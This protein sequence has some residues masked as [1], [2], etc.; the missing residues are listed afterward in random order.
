MDDRAGTRALVID[1]VELAGR[2]GRAVRLCDGRVVA[3]GDRHQLRGDRHDVVIDGRGGALLRGLHDHHLHLWS[4][5]A[6]LASVRCGPPEVADVH[7]MAEALRTV[8]ARHPPGEWLRGIGYHESVAGEL[9]RTVLDGMVADRPVRIQHRSG[10]LWVLNTQ[11]TLRCGLPPDSDGRLVR[12]DHEFRDRWS[13]PGTPPDLAAVGHLLAAA[14][15]TG[16]TDATATNGRK[17]LA[18]LDTAS[19]AGDIQ[20]RILVLGGPDMPW[21]GPGP[22]RAPGPDLSD[23]VTVG[24]LKIVLDEHDLP[25]LDGCEGLSTAIVDAHRIGRRVAV[26][27]VTEAALILTLSA[28]DTAG[29][30]AGDRIEHASLVPAEVLPWMARLGLTVVTQPNFVAERGDRYREDLPPGSLPKLYR[31]ATL[32]QAGVRLAAGTDAPF[33]DP[34]PWRAMRAA[35]DRR[36]AAGRVLGPEDRL[37][38]E[39]ALAL[40]LGPPARPG[41][42]PAAIEVGGRADLCLLRVPWAAARRELAR[43]LVAATVCGGR[44]V[45]LADPAVSRLN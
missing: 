16:V 6:S 7:G 14:G 19:A 21:P 37:D 5:A 4:L 32:L 28:F 39:Q 11:A 26:H 45:H 13:E 17:E 31:A 1:D 40:F 41:G 3:V 22:F 42:P 33:G 24:G 15:I 29:A 18:A 36:T 2:P 10:I 20:Q 34:D 35:V 38:P 25:G 23:R 12:L 30:I 8:A 27:V 9:D 44:L 43:E